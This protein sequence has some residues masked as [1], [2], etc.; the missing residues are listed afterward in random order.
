MYGSVSKSEVKPL[1]TGVDLSKERMVKEY[2]RQ[3]GLCFTCGDKFE[4]GHQNKCPKRLQMQLN[5]LTAEEL[6]MT[7]ADEVLSQLEQD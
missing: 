5:A 7:L 4:P 6:G 3:Q 2:R 1:S